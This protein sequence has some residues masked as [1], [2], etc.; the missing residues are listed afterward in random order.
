MQMTFQVRFF[1]RCFNQIV[2][3]N[4]SKNTQL[5]EETEKNPV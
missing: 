5:I 1:A 2:K 3:N 4:E